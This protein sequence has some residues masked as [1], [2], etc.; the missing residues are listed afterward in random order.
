[1]DGEA[2]RSCSLK[3]HKTCGASHRHLQVIQQEAHF[4]SYFQG[5][6]QKLG[7]SVWI[8]ESLKELFP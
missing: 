1:M 5:Q 2:E 3:A 8:S 6:T 7:I 4:M